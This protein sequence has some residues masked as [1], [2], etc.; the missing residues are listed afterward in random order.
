[1]P[2]VTAEDVDA[3]ALLARL[4]LE[5]AEKAALRSELSAILD[6]FAA[7]ADVDTTGVEP[8]T[9]AVPVDLPLRSDEPSPSLPPAEALR[10]APAARDDFFVVPAVLPDA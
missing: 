2:T 4:H 9:H 8:M 6:Y 1:M 5:P 7:L 10:N 3:I